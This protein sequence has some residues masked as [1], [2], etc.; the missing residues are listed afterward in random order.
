MNII[1]VRNAA[2]VLLEVVCVVDGRVLNHLNKPLGTAQE[3]GVS[4]YVPG[5]CC[6]L[7]LWR[8]AQGEVKRSPSTTVPPRPGRCQHK[9]L[10]LKP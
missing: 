10:N 4:A 3:C 7:Q 8:P 2:R 9:T 1:A 6:V 5:V